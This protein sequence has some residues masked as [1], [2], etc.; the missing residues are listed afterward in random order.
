MNQIEKIGR[1]EKH[2]PNHIQIPFVS[3]EKLTE[4]EGV[5]GFIYKCPFKI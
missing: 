2:F 5:T 1:I 4:D 3:I